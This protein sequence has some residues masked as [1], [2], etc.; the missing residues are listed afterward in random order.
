M[1]VVKHNKDTSTT[2]FNNDK[3]INEYKKK[4]KKQ[5]FVKFDPEQMRSNNI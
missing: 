1:R 2:F 3:E 4:L 5:G